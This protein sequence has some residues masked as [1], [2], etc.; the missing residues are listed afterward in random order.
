MAK[1]SDLQEIA[2]GI[3]R[4]KTKN[5]QIIG[6]SN[7]TNNLFDEFYLAL[8]KDKFKTDE[9]YAYHFYDQPSNKKAYYK[10]KE[11]LYERLLNT[12]FFI[13]QITTT[14]DELALMTA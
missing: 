1:L 7:K 14:S 10:L 13:D 3:S 5:I 4:N 12:I 8:T 6:N 2:K 11:R 9:E